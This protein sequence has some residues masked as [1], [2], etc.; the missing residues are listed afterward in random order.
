MNL[1]NRD[2]RN[3]R[4]VTRE[5][6][7][8]DF[9][10]YAHSSQQKH[11]YRQ[12]QASSSKIH[13]DHLDAASGP[14]ITTIISRTRSRGN[15][16]EGKM[17]VTTST[18]AGSSSSAGAGEEQPRGRH[19][20]CL[21]KTSKLLFLA[22]HGLAFVCL[23]A[24]VLQYEEICGTP[25]ILA[26]RVSL[27]AEQDE[28]NRED[29]QG[30]GRRSTNLNGGSSTT[31]MAEADPIDL[32]VPTTTTAI[33]S[34]SHSS[35]S[36][37]S[38]TRSAARTE[39]PSIEADTI[40]NTISNSGGCPGGGQNSNYL[41]GAARAPPS[42][43]EHEEP[44]Q[45]MLITDAV[46]T[47]HDVYA[48]VDR[49]DDN[50][51]LNSDNVDDSNVIS[52]SEGVG[53][54]HRIQ[55]RRVGRPVDDD[56]AEQ[57]RSVVGRHPVYADTEQRPIP[58][59]LVFMPIFWIY[60]VIFF[61]LVLSWVSSC[62]YIKRCLRENSAI[63]HGSRHNPSLITEIAPRV[64]VAGAAL[65]FLLVSL[66]AEVSTYR[67]LSEDLPLTWEYRLLPDEQVAFSWTT[68]AMR[69]LDIR[70]DPS[71][72]S[73]TTATTVATPRST[74]S[75]ST[76]SSTRRVV[77]N[78]PLSGDSLC[79]RVPIHVTT[80]ILLSC[81][82]AGSYGVLVKRRSFVAWVSAYVVLTAIL[83]QLSS[84]GE[85]V[86]WAPG[87]LLSLILA[88]RACARL[89]EV[90][91]VLT[92]EET[93]WRCVEV[94]T[95]F[96]LA[97]VLAL[98]LLKAGLYIGRGI[99]AVGLAILFLVAVRTRLAVLNSRCRLETRMVLFAT[100]TSTGEEPRRWPP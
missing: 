4:A 41:Q 92:N 2:Q 52:T 81:F 90:W 14:R 97:W 10:T 28:Y 66:I 63:A 21:V 54:D 49:G 70:A 23:G 69:H 68:S 84:V 51:V 30:E 40:T 12:K 5:E 88:V 18:G 39:D 82:I 36:Y 61:L 100:T 50:N 26:E 78:P 85:S 71:T 65:F 43:Q 25:T 86:K 15:E 47:F 20:E 83:L 96:G 73:A 74:T 9:L 80:W 99:S 31:P 22:A 33:A 37:S 79:L 16:N 32:D 46:Q 35:L 11:N 34:H 58:W 67:F 95:G 13:I 56:V 45:I 77:C 24:K 87:I 59:S 6:H 89:L 93:A 3:K 55:T 1:L 53:E 60:P 48:E 64:L 94:V 19:P 7:G 62:N 29:H 91:R 76:L 42:V 72:S 38:T 44:T 27:G 8:F 75:P 98:N 17:N 57:T